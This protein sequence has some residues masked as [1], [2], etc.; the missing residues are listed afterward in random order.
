MRRFL[1]CLLNTILPP[2]CL[3][4]RKKFS[5]LVS[6]LLCE[7]CFAGIEINNAFFCPKC[8]RR[9]Y[10]NK[11]V[12][13]REEKLVLAAAGSYQNQSLRE[14]IH[15]LK[16]RGLK[17][18]VPLLAEILNGY[19][20]KIFRNSPINFNEFSFIPLPLHF[21]KEKERGFNQTILIADFLAAQKNFK[22]EKSVLV[23]NKETKPQAQLKSGDERKENI[24]NCFVIKNK[25]KIAGRNIILF[26]DVFTSG[27][28]MREAV[29]V[30]KEAGAKKIIGLVIAKA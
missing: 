1:Y 17:T 11:N 19:L 4:C 8:E 30:L 15:A 9:L 10:D 24:K 25:E 6:P 13:H 14:L 12:C 16:Y 28:T 21:K 20:E 3:A 5:S 29:R 22:I 27:A 18:A 26:D 2:Q 23:K 7:K